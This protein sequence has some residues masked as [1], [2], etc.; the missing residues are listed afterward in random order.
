[1]DGEVGKGTSLDECSGQE[2]GGHGVLYCSYHCRLK[3][4][5]DSDKLYITVGTSHEPQ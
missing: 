5:A 1:M 4:K 3:P 2:G